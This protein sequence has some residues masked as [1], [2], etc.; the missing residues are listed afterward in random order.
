MCKK[1]VTKVMELDSSVPHFID[2]IIGNRIIASIRGFDEAFKD[3][4]IYIDG[5]HG[6]NSRVLDYI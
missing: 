5:I 3:L 1:C 6:K 4:V 2:G